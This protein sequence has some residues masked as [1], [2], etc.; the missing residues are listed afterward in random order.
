MDIHEMATEQ[1]IA[2]KPERAEEYE[3]EAE[4]QPDVEEYEETITLRA[5]NVY[6]LQD[7]SRTS[8]F[9][10]R[11]YREM[12]TKIGS[13]YKPCCKTFNL[14][15]HLHQGHLLQLHFEYSIPL[16]YICIFCIH[17]LWTL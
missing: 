14:D 4:D 7:P 6:A 3:E 13:S 15:C 17:T 16:H 11:I 8:D 1:E 12:H 9:R 5:A 2:A 10:F